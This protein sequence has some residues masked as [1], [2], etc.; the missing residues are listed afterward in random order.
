MRALDPPKV[1]SLAHN[2][3]ARIRG[4]GQILAHFTQGAD[5]AYGRSYRALRTA[6]ALFIVGMTDVPNSE[7]KRAAKGMWHGCL[8]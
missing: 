3:A 2:W 1:R 4:T 7:G 5:A 6:S 8:R